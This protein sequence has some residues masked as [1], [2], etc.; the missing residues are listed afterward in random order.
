MATKITPAEWETRKETILN[1]RRL[2]VKVKGKGGI[3]ERMKE[4]YG[5]TAR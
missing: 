4:V 5:F 2:G 1:M 3:V